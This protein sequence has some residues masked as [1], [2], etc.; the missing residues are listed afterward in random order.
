MTKD[1]FIFDM[2]GVIVDS[3]PAH[4]EILKKVFEE[5]SLDFSDAYHQTL[6]GMAAIPMWEKIKLDFDI[7]TNARELMNFHKEFLFI[8]MNAQSVEAVPGVLD[9][10][11][12][13]KTLDFRISLASSS[14]IKLIEQFINNLEITSYFDYLV[15]GENV[16][17]SKPNPDIFL[18]VADNYKVDPARFLVIED[19]R[20]GVKAAKAAGMTCIGFKNVNSG[21]QDLSSAD[22][23]VDSFAELTSEKIKQLAS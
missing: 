16:V 15:S 8:E 13:L 22:I 18:K 14:S 6:V 5:L 19:S 9:F 4:K 3:E 1:H 2:D 20:N 23:I 21:N 11:Q 12:Q 10:L 17:R 7:E